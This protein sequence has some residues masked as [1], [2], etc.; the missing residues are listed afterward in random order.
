VLRHT[1]DVHTTSLIDVL[2][3]PLLQAAYTHELDFSAATEV[4]ETVRGV[5]RNLQNPNVVAEAVEALLPVMGDFA[6]LLEPKSP[7]T[8]YLPLTV[9]VLQLLHAAIDSCSTYLPTQLMDQLLSLME[10]V[11]G[12]SIGRLH[13]AFARTS[14]G[15]GAVLRT[16]N[17]QQSQDE[18]ERCDLLVTITKL[19]LTCAVWGAFDLSTFEP[20]DETDRIRVDRVSTFCVGGLL[21]VVAIL[22]RT[23]HAAD[24]LN[25]PAVG[26]SLC[27]LLREVANT[28]A[29]VLMKMPSA[30]QAGDILWLI[31]SA[32][33]VA[34]VDL[35]ISAYGTVSALAKHAKE[36]RE[37]G[38]GTNLEGSLGEFVDDLWAVFVT[39][40]VEVN[41]AAAHAGA[42]M[43]LSRAL[44]PEH[45]YNAW[46]AAFRDRQRAVNPESPAGAHIDSIVRTA[47]MDTNFTEVRS[48]STNAFI[49]ELTSALAVLRG[50]SVT[51]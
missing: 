41:A 42:I 11:V 19:L 51:L 4:A 44:G 8:F 21:S 17:A 23:P 26:S 22:S 33:A 6:M 31:R 24:L 40:S 2:R 43:S 50:A 28:H 36:S 34:D 13:D 20:N 39:C 25:I 7:F 29:E 12:A 1:C 30:D 45:V 35:N 46:V 9:S 15:A 32:I 47:M 16:T 38:V 48:R 27:C 18:D 37:R 10:S 3:Q 5:V 49:G 14:G